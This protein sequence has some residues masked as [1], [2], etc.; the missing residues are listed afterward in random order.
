M[1]WR[2]GIGNLSYVIA[3]GSAVIGVFN[4]FPLG[5][6]ISVFVIFLGLALKSFFPE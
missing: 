4:D 6:I 5:V 1:N 2:K 3:G